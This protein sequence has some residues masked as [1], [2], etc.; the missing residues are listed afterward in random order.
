[1]KSLK[2][3]SR[4]VVYVAGLRRLVLVGT[5]LAHPST[6]CLLVM[7]SAIPSSALGPAHLAAHSSYLLDALMPLGQ[8]V[9]GK[10]NP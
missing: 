5:A 6:V 7:N 10:E 1:M 3:G 2:A 4:Q 9:G 8:Q